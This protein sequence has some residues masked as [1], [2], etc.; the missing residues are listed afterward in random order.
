M[1]NRP[2][3]WSES[4]FHYLS[5]TPGIIPILLSYF[6]FIN[7]HVVE[8]FDITVVPV[9]YRWYERANLQKVLV[10]HRRYVWS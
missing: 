3:Q 9:S 7:L 6:E 4:I 5:I 10:F 8:E 1:V 2:I